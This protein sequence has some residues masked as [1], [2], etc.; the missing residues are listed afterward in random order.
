MRQGP[1]GSRANAERYLKMAPAQR[2]PDFYCATSD[3]RHRSLR[4]G[5]IGLLTD[6]LSSSPKDVILAPTDFRR[7]ILL[8]PEIV[9]S[10]DAMLPWWDWVVHLP[11][12]W[13]VGT[14]VK[15]AHTLHCPVSTPARCREHGAVEGQGK[16]V[17]CVPPTDLL[18]L[19]R[20][21]NTRSASGEAR[22]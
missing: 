12:E 6:I 2:A 18:S 7:G 9:L 22:G 5:R 10:A 19:G 11:A 8:C 3:A 15:M 21:L 13:T 17:G 1:K 16:A 14:K 4:S 20:S